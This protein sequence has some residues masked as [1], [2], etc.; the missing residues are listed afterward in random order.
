MDKLVQR[1]HALVANTDTQF[2]RYEHSL[3]D[4]NDRMKAVVGARGILCNK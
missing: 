2:L 3:I 4:W 1:F